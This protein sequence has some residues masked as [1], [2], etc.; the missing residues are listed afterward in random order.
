MSK[1]VYVKDILEAVDGLDATKEVFIVESVNK[2]T[3]RNGK[4]Y[5]RLV[6][7]DKSGSILA[8]IWQDYFPFCGINNIQAGDVIEV[9]FRTENYNDQP[10]VIITALKKADDYNIADLIQASDKDIDLM[11]T[12]LYQLI[13]SVNDK[14]IKKLLVSIFKEDSDIV[15]KLKVI[16]AGEKVHHD[17]VGGLLEHSLEVVEIALS[18]YKHYKKVANKDL[19]IAGALLHDIGKI[20]EFDF[21]NF[22]FTRTKKGYLIGHIVMAVELINKKITQN[23]PEELRVQLVHIILSHHHD[24]ELGAVVRPATIEADIVA[25]AD[26]ASSQVRQFQKELSTKR[27]DEQGFGEYHKFLKTKVYFSTNSNEKE[28]NNVSDSLQPNE[29]TSTEDNSTSKDR[30]PQARLI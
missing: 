27:P 24:L 4:P 18:I 5:Y 8:R 23:F 26:Y 15:D 10:Q 13:D 1:K 14:N 30:T 3:T 2:H 16:P 9:D 29:T 25:M 12:R 17:Y 6:L 22:V 19:V 20:Y 11:F 7:K 28:D 21:K